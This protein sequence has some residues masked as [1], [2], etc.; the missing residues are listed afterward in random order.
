MVRVVEFREY[1]FTKGRN[2]GHILVLE[3]VAWTAPA[4]VGE[5]HEEIIFTD[6]GTRDDDQ[7]GA[8]LL[9]LAF[10]AGMI[11]PRDAA[12]IQASGQELDLDFVTGLPDRVFM[13]DISKRKGKDDKEFTNIS[14][15]G[16]AIYHCKDPKTKDWPKHQALLN[17]AGALIGE[18]QPLR[19]DDV[20]F[21]P[22]KKVD[23]AAV[24]PFAAKV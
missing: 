7:C 1:G 15:G 8:K 16:F 5:Q 24:N 22:D 12:T 9:K 3:I 19:K 18:W 13:T 6:D 11:T 2:P 10:A 23:V 14:E 20:P 21:T 4:A 17:Q